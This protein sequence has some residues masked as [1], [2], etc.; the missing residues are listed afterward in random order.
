MFTKHNCGVGGN[1]GGN[2]GRIK[3]AAVAVML[4]ALAACAS[5]FK[6]DVSRFQSQLPPPSGQTFTV[7]PQDSALK[8]SIEFAHYAQ[9]VEAQMIR[10]GYTLA[11]NPEQ[12]TL[13]V[14]FDYGVDGGR[15]RVRS[16][17]GSSW[18]G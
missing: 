10:Q 7:V 12:A 4:L 6:A 3:A 9:L 13:L 11:S 15:E 2:A 1:I 5:P 8:G 18:G 14:R 16:W 17:G